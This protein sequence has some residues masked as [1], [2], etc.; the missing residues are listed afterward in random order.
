MGK[1]GKASAYRFVTAWDLPAPVARVWVELRDIGAWSKW[2]RGFERV[3]LVSEGDESGVGAILDLTSR[4][5]LPYRLHYRL[6]I[7]KVEHEHLVEMV[8]SG[9]LA[10]FGRWTLTP[11]DQGT[12]AEY[13][14]DVTTTGWLFRALS[15]IAR[16]TFSRNHD[17]VME[18]G[19]QG[20][21]QRLGATADA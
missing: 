9:E 19:R 12:H 18:W 16:G 7:V 17:A 6:E 8:S 15:P 4:G 11:T 10:G 1:A 3:E 5:R 21:L 20:M 2:W 14:W 13:L